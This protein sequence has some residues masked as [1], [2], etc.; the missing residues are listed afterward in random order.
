LPKEFE[1]G[2]QRFRDEVRPAASE[3]VALP[4]EML[5]RIDPPRNFDLLALV[6]IS[7]C[8]PILCAR[9]PRV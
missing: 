7:D 9:G 4:R 1:A 6:P 5:E 3:A 2:L 8:L